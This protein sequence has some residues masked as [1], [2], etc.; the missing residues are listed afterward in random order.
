VPADV[1]FPNI[2]PYYFNPISKTFCNFSLVLNKANHRHLFIAL[3]PE[4][5]EQIKSAQNKV[6]FD[7]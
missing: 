2:A 3:G 6:C 1:S 4:T 5:G 7:L